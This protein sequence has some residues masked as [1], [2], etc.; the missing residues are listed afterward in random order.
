ME[1]NKPFAIT[2]VGAE[3]SGKTTL[4][5]Q[6]AD[7]YQCAVVPEYAREYLLSIDRAYTEADLAIIAEQEWERI[8]VAM[9]DKL[10]R[11]SGRLIID[12]GMLTLRMWARIKFQIEIPIVEHAL[13][14]DDTNLYI[15]CRPRTF[16]ESDPLR[17]APDLVDRAWIYNQYLAELVKMQTDFEIRDLK[18]MVII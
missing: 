10:A 2:I 6:L 17:E 13:K 15:L 18:G 9:R 3:S 7:Q 16:W 8:Q 12:G 11:E 5:T 4:A 1:E 14:N